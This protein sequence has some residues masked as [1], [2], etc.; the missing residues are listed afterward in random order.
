VPTGKR[1]ANGSV[2]AAPI[3]IAMQARA[4]NLSNTFASPIDFADKMLPA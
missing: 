1:H 4:Q 3:E 2:N